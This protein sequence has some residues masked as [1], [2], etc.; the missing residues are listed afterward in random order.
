MILRFTILIGVLAALIASPASADNGVR[1]YLSLGDSLAAG[2]QPTLRP[3]Q[4]FG[5]EGYADQLYALEQ[6][7]IPELMLVKLGCGGETTGSM[8]DPFPYE[9]RGDHF[10][11]RFP[12]GSQLADALSFLHAHKGNVA[13]VTIDIGAN[14]VFQGVPL[15][16]LL[17]NLQLILAQLREAAGPNVP[18]VGMN[19][20]DP[21]LPQA[22]SVGG[23]SALEAE[24]AGV[25]ALNDAF[26]SV[27]AAA[28]DSVA[29]VEAAFSTTDTTLVNGTP[30]DVLRACEWTWFC[31]VGD[32]H[33]N[34][35][36]YGVM[37][38]AFA[39]ALP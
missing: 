26:E 18:I 17:A 14:D 12:H 21:F 30:L 6:A 33:A 1:Y 29:D 3:G 22:W 2:F 4:N 27:Y 7:K 10:F 11:C 20:Y 35:T 31:T 38:Q 23:L 13:F 37:A 9:G 25:T 19:Y 39:A 16:V 24:I 34:A 32:I 8:S 28:G 36:G 15:P 5:D